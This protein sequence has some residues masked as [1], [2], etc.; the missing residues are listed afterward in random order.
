[1]SAFAFSA[2][3]LLPHQPVQQRPR[4]RHVYVDETRL[5]FLRRPST[6]GISVGKMT[7]FHYANLVKPN[8]RATIG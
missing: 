5:H 6:V 1:M 4:Q 8:P 3:G 7:V 2:R